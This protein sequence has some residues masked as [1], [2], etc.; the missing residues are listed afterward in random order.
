M[1]NKKFSLIVS[2]VMVFTLGFYFVT[3]ESRIQVDSGFDSSFD[4]SSSS[5]WDSSSSSSS[6]SRSSSSYNSSHSS[7]RSSSSSYR[8]DSSSD[9]NYNTINLLEIDAN[10]MA[11]I[12]VFTF[13]LI[14]ALVIIAKISARNSKKLQENVEE[15]IDNDK[16]YDE[17]IN[18]I[19]DDDE[20]NKKKI[21]QNSEMLLNKLLEKEQT[22]KEEFYKKLFNIY[23]DVQISWMNFDYDKMKNLVSD[24]MFNMY[25]SQLQTLELSNQKKIMK[26]IK[27]NSCELLSLEENEEA[28][29]IKVKL[30]VR[31]YDYIVNSKTNDLIKGYKDKY[32]FYEYEI[33]FIKNKNINHS[34][35]NCG[36]KLEKN[37]NKCPSCGSIILNNNEEWVM[38][39]KKMV[40]QR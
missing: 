19:I 3:N 5:S 29:N 40:N 26:K 10:Q 8:S 13:I 6:S 1:K 31:C 39:K 16:S 33:E 7:R 20:K 15:G 9:H 30:N 34:C 28:L 25:H 4:Y 27:Y 22:T 24:E 38:S 23:K 18:K 35:I 36:T 37:M 14:V 2:I 17:M 11:I 12:C 32:W 21:K